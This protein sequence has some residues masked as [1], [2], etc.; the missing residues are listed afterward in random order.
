MSGSAEVAY[1]QVCLFLSLVF[2]A[3]LAIVLVL[4]LARVEPE[5]GDELSTPFMRGEDVSELSGQQPS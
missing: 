4:V 5:E 1:M 3:G 2:N